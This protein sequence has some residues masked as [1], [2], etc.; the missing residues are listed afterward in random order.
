MG[1]RSI[2]ELGPF[3]FVLM[4]SIGDIMAFIVLEKK[5]PFYEGAMILTTLAV[6]E[7]ILSKITFKSKKLAVIIEGR[8]TKLIEDGKLIEDNMNREKISNYDVRKEL[9]NH[10]ITDES[11]VRIATIES[12][13]KFTVI[14]KDEEDVITKKEF[15][16]EIE[17]LNKTINNLI[18]EL[19]NNNKE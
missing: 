3:D 15:R 12:C 9:R 7:I 1:K 18:I 14:L 5:V 6:V 11:Q 4:A 8:P 2:G 17:K 16:K 19:A 10:G 13:G